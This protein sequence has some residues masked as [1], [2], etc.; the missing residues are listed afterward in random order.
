VTPYFIGRPVTEWLADGR[1]M[2]M[3]EPFTF[4]DASGLQW[5]VYEGTTIDGSSIPR[6]I[7]P[8]TGSPF[9]GRH[10]DASIPHDL[11]CRIR[12]RPSK[13][14]HRM[15]YDACIASGVSGRSAK[16][17]YWGVR[18]FGPKW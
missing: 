7:W 15:Y 18:R 1:L 8:M 12:T 17:K 2:R 13:M 10:R 16:M 6:M 11:F 4:V 5:D 9:V 14:V 3:K